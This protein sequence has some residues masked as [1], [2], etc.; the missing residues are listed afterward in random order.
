MTDSPVTPDSFDPNRTDLFIDRPTW[1]KVIWIISISW[2]CF[3]M[4]CGLLM[5]V[6]MFFMNSQAFTE[7]TEKGMGA[8]MPD[9]FRP[10]STMWAFGA[11]G[12]LWLLV[13]LFAGLA[14]LRHRDSGRGL[15]LLWA[16]VAVVLGCVS[17]VLQAKMLSG[18]RVWVEANPDSAWGKQF[19]PVGEF[20]GTLVGMAISFSYPLFLIIWFGMGKGKQRMK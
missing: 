4:M 2:A 18:K 8:P 20:I 1:P 10:S 7:M 16:V 13:L 14:T 19:S 6:G 9:A 5:T 15:H 17:M 3:W 11:V 12:S